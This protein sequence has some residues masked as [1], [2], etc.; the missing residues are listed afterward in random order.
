MD[1]RSTA[2]WSIPG[3]VTSIVYGTRPLTRWP[4]S[5]IPEK[6]GSAVPRCS[7]VMRAPGR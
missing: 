3:S 2:A 1:D 5:I 7:K 6:P 4:A